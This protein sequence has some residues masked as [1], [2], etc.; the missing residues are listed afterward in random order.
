MDFLVEL[1][2][3]RSPLDLSGLIFD[4]QEALGRDVDVVAI[5]APSHA[6]SR[7]MQDELP[8]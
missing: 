6:A 3:G 8:L 1:D 5:T 2:Q 4:L 7:I